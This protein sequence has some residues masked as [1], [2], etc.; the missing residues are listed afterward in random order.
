MGK[1]ICQWDLLL[2]QAEFAYIIGLL[3]KPQVVVLLKLSMALTLL[4]LLIWLQFLLLLN[5]VAM[6]MNEPRE[7]RSYMSRFVAKLRRKM[8]SIV[9]KPISIQKPM[10]FKEGD[11][12]SIHL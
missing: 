4:V 12:V 10:T 3:V 2:A 5:L 6:R 7:S 11:L 8:R 1:N 9:C